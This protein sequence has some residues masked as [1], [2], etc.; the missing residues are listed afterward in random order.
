MNSLSPVELAR[1]KEIVSLPT[2]PFCEAAIQLYIEDWARK[3][4]IDCHRDPHGNL[5]LTYSGTEPTENP[6]WVLQAHMD[7]PGFSYIKRRASTHWAS[8]RGGVHPDYFAG[9]KVTFYPPHDAPLSGT[10]ES[11][12]RD[13]KTGT[14]TCRIKSLETR[15]IPSGTL[16][17]WEL[18]PWQKRGN[19]LHLR[20]VDDLCGVAA[21]LLT[22]ERLNAQKAPRKTAALLTRAEEVGFVGA[23]AAAK[24]GTLPT[25]WPVL[26]IE[27]SKAQPFAK[28]GRGAIIRLGDRASLFDHQLTMQLRHAAQQLQTDQPDLHFTEALMPGGSC[29]STGLALH[30]Y[31]T[32][33][34][35]L[36]LGNY[37]NMG[38]NR[39]IAP[40]QIDLRDFQSLLAL[41]THIAQTNP[42]T[43]NH[44]AQLTE[45]LE[46]NYARWESLL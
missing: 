2:A 3:T 5:L 45:R 33:A 17:M 4:A 44:R 41:L 15:D 35:C 23:I 10:I 38:P 37:H 34:L 11:T 18:P 29:E 39:T 20:V 25:G 42:D 24:A 22:L 46:K 9:A 31:R 7:H 40:E 12:K 6:P 14:L 32:C 21:I 43:Q 28:I 19:R 16:G 30:G 27:A 26:G 13:P 8:F 36:P 1:L